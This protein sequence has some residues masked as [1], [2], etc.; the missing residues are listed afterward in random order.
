MKTLVR[1]LLAV[2]VALLIIL[3]SCTQPQTE[4]QKSKEV[5]FSW[6]QDIGSLNPHPG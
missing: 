2:A 3:P 6:F 5:V 4:I 1:A